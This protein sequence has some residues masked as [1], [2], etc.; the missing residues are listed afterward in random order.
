MLS[1]AVALVIHAFTYYILAWHFGLG[2]QVF[3]LL[4]TFL[5]L[6]FSTCVFQT[7]TQTHCNGGPFDV[8]SNIGTKLYAKWSQVVFLCA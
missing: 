5:Y 1:I 4:E 6:L 2:I 8:I 7:L 3:P